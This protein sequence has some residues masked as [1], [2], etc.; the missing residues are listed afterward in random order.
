[1]LYVRYLL[2]Y[3]LADKHD[4]HPFR[5]FK[6]LYVPLAPLAIDD[7]NVLVKLGNYL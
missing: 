3:S 2:T 5:W 7:F 1:M 4:L 6:L